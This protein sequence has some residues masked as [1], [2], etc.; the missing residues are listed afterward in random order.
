MADTQLMVLD[1]ETTVNSSR[2]NKADPF[3]PANR[4]VTM[5]WMFDQCDG[6]PASSVHIRDPYKTPILDVIFDETHEC[7]INLLVGHHIEFDLHY[8]MRF[9]P[10]VRKRLP[11]V[12]IWDTQIAEFILENQQNPFP[13]LDYCSEKRG[14]TLKDDRV[15]K[16][17][18]AGMKTE[19]IPEEI[20][21]AYL[22]YDVVN[23]H[24]VFKSQFAEAMERGML[25]LIIMRM[26]ALL[27][28]IEMT[29][30][31]LYVDAAELA[32]GR[33]ELHNR[34]HVL[35]NELVDIVREHT[36]IT[37]I[38]NPDSPKQVERVL[39]G[40]IEITTHKEQRGTFKNGNPKWV[41]IDK[42][43]KRAGFGLPPK[44]EW[45]T[46][47]GV[48]TSDEVLESLSS[49][50][51][52]PEWAF[53]DR[54]REYRDKKKQLSTYYDGIEERLYDNQWIHHKLNHCIAKTGR[55]TSSDP[56]L[57]NVTSGDASSSVNIKKVFT[58]RWG[59]N[60]V[61]MEADFKQ[62]EIVVLAY[63]TGDEQL[64]SD[65]ESG[66]DMHTE[67]FMQVNRGRTPTKDERKQFKRASFALVYGG[68]ATAISKQAGIGKETA[69]LF[70]ETFYKRYPG[71][72]KWHDDMYKHVQFVANHNDGLKDEHGI[73]IAK[74]V[75]QTV[76]GRCY[77][78]RQYEPPEWMAKAHSNPFLRTFSPQEVKNYPVQGTATG[79]IVPMMLGRIYR[80]LKSAY[81]AFQDRAPVLVNT[82]HDSIML[83]VP[84][85]EVLTVAGILKYEIERT[86]LYFKETF[87]KDFNLKLSCE[88]SSGPNWLDQEEMKHIVPVPPEVHP[89]FEE[90]AA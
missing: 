52:G 50:I 42:E 18:E 5:G 70:I 84:K 17:W 86:H 12:R 41:S 11:F 25:P 36:N 31:G 79:D 29:F 68:G 60:G 8:L 63:L 80:R 43:H 2:K 27:A 21:D 90:E 78:F 77:E 15:K 69:K 81:S 7:P 26:E 35:N 3:D 74:A 6:E 49:T 59:K 89:Q 45:R 22:R 56:N 23:T 10:S 75:I 73:P 83:D 47:T 39:F 34:L 16:M 82:V 55:L 4:I 76:T 62:L 67:L 13:S 58:S 88:I 20:L 33:S 1:L 66:A 64:I 46:K 65:L 87:G 44:E 71:I 54:L 72:K 48:S 14:G 53:I 28:T 40:G 61:I 30:N 24:I 38:F 37:E 32:K 19:D 85:S 57:Q 9:F 51:Y